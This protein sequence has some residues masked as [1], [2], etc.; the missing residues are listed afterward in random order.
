MQLR[1]PTGLTGEQYVS[2]RAWR[3]ARLDRCP[4]HPHGGC[5]FA[6]HGTYIRKTPRGARIARWYCPQS[7]T[8]FSLLPDCLAAR[9]PGTLDALEEAVVHAEN[10]SSLEVAANDLRPDAVNLPGAKR[11]VQ[12]RIRLVHRSLA[13][14]VELLPELFC[15]GVSRL[16]VLRRHLGTDRALT[17]VRRLIAPAVP[18]PVGFRFPNDHAAGLKRVFQHE[19]GPDPPPPDA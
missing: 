13:V 2:T 5:G 11:W 17:K 18:A 15:P 16:N 4:N 12:R 19:M 7:R 8:T 6:R 10:A 9:L 3:N 14:A 1:F